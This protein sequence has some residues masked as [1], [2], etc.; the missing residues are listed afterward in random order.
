MKITAVKSFIGYGT[1][2][3]WVFLRIETDEGLHGI[4]QAQGGVL[5][6]MVHEAMP[7]LDAF[8]LGEDSSRIDY[9]WTRLFSEFNSTG[10]RGFG[11]ALISAVDIALWDIKGKRLGLPIYELLGGKFR[12]NLRL[13]SN[14][15]MPQ[16]QT[17]EAYAKA[18]YETVAE[19]HTALKMDPF[20][21]FEDVAPLQIGHNISP[22]GLRKGVEITRSVRNAIGDDIELLIDLHGRYDVAAA[23]RVGQALGEFNIGWLEEPVPPENHDALQIVKEQ[24]PTPICVGER[25]VT[26]WD[27]RPILD[28]QLANYIMPDI[29][30]CG[31]ISEMRKIATMA[32]AYYI[33]VSPHDAT[34]P[35]TMAAGAQVMMSTPNFYRLEIAYSEVPHYNAAL[36]P[37]LDVRNG[38]YHVPD[39][40]GLGHDLNEAYLEAGPEVSLV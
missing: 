33:P 8:L 35:I 25:L 36:M 12:D 15:W 9:I 19:G 28:K 34:G 11:S 22:N 38:F 20:F 23:V 39:A 24:V 4:G 10:N 16:E 17:P 6:Q 14:G 21:D 30:R 7:H 13:Y 40:P 29:V 37:T 5:A 1:R 3:P 27:F 32:E 31:G 2:Y 26:R 18:A